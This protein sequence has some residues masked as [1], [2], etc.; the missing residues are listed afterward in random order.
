MYQ[1]Q[2]I[3][4]WYPQIVQVSICVHVPKKYNHLFFSKLRDT[5]IEFYRWSLTWED[6]HCWLP[7]RFKSKLIHTI[8][9]LYTHTSY[10]CFVTSISQTRLFLTN[11]RRKLFFF[12]QA[13]RD[14]RGTTFPDANVSMAY[15]ADAYNGTLHA[16]ACIYWCVV[17]DLQ[18][19]LDALSLICMHFLVCC[20]WSACISWCVVLDLH[21]FPGV[22]S[23]ICMHFLVCCPWSACIS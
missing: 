7:L 17:L 13:M 20:P 23:L 12:S 11:F 8:I 1:S 18:S 2:G 21:A 16:S 10:P 14:L 5:I 9:L 19:F 6:Q 22:L 4:F 3:F 15:V